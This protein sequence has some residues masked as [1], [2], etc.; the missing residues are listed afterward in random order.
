V[1]AAGEPPP[2]RPP[3]ERRA[4]PAIVWIAGTLAVVGALV[5]AWDPPTSPQAAAVLAMPSLPSLPDPAAP[6]GRAA[7][8][9]AG[10]A[11]PPTAASGTEL[12]EVCGVGWVPPDASGAAD[13]AA[14]AGDRDVLASQRALLDGLRNADGELG[15]ARATVLEL[16]GGGR[17]NRDGTPMQALSCA[18]AGQAACAGR[19]ED[20]KLATT[21]V[22]R[23][24]KR[25]AATSDARV[26]A[27]AMQECQLAR[28][29]GSCALLSPD[30]W[31][32]LD[33]G[34]ALP[35]LYILQ[36][37]RD[38]ND[39]AQMEEALYRI[40][41]ATRYETSM[42]A[43]AGK[44]ADRAGA[45]DVDTVAALLLGVDAV[46][47][48]AARNDPFQALA[49]ACRGAAL[50]DANRRQACEL[51][52]A[53]LAERSDSLAAGVIGASIGRRLGWPADRVDKLRGLPLAAA[54]EADSIM[55]GVFELPSSCASARRIL[56]SFSRKARDGEVRTAQAWVTSHGGPA[57]FVAPPLK[58][59]GEARAD[60]SAQVAS[61]V[62][63]AASDAA[64]ASLAA[65]APPPAESSASSVPA[66]TMA[67]TAAS[68]TPYSA[69]P[70]PD[71]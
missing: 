67:D 23:L 3:P 17:E 68:A 51:A 27:L 21:L 56:A 22:E 52:A 44:V 62:A 63:Q 53:T 36:R 46:G 48:A 14:V 54:A 34:N 25:A 32:R 43:I 28:G 55:S 35:W 20:R 7:S 4:W 41:M 65:A 26:Y 39:A 66:A 31:A 8:A 33:D 70:P 19:E 10:D 50:A 49:Q 45:S 58:V 13:V 15:Q 5:F 40:G 1:S 57:A 11:L 24:A 38:R 60:E 59:A 29:Q 71:R 12:I 42:F 16:H 37:A 9:D 61:P 69:T 30:Q 64:S 6:S 2:F 47:V 18:D